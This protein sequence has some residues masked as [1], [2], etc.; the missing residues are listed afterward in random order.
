MID[1]DGNEVPCPG[2]DECEDEDCDARRDF[3]VT[4]TYYIT[5]H[6]RAHSE[7]DAKTLAGEVDSMPSFSYE[8]PVGVM[9]DWSDGGDT[10]FYVTD[11]VAR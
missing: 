9:D 7:A 2:E 6:V 11:P 8:A 4:Y 1:D 10:E 5:A 3:E